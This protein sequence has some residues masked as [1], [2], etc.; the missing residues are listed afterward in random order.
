MKFYH[1]K[2]KVKLSLPKS[3]LEKVEKEFGSGKMQSEK[4]KNHE[5]S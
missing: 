4:V 1:K 5:K 3:K 2:K